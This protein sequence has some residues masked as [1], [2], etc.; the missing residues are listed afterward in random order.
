MVLANKAAQYQGGWSNEAITGVV[1]AIL[2]TILAILVL[3]LR[4]WWRRRL[5]MQTEQN[6]GPES[7]DRVDQTDGTLLFSYS[8][9]VCSNG[10]SIVRV[11]QER[12]R[13]HGIILSLR[14]AVI[15]LR[16]AWRT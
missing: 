8:S 4:S 2:A 10:L 1:G 5:A 11:A 3:L 15:V 6:R 12:N 9:F 16:V 13:K 14:R 7:P